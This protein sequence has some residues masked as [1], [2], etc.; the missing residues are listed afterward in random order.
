MDVTS[1]YLMTADR[2]NPKCFTTSPAVTSLAAW[3]LQG[4]S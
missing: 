1:T 2:I 4:K 3:S